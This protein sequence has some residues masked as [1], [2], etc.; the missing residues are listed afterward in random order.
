MDSMA[1]L[2]KFHEVLGET[3]E[4]KDAGD[5]DSGRPEVCENDLSIGGNI[6]FIFI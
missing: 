6:L 2:F 5:A 3:K 1:P 4:T